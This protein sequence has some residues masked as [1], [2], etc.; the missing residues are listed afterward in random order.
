MKLTGDFN[1]FAAPQYAEI[2]LFPRIR[3]A[4]GFWRGRDAVRFSV[5]AAQKFYQDF[6]GRYPKRAPA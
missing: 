6:T 4:C 3:P 1:D 5:N 2:C